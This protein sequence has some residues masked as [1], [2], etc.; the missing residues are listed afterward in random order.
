MEKLAVVHARGTGRRPRDHFPASTLPFAKGIRLLDLRSEESAETEGAASV[1]GRSSP[2]L[3]RS[4][5][6]RDSFYVSSLPSITSL[7]EAD[8]HV[9]SGKE[10]GSEKGYL[11]G[12]AWDSLLECLE[13]SS[14]L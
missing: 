6:T 7:A 14:C 3:G 13:G 5:E 2:G 8:P 12:P 1:V 4:K 10:K 11:A 9:A